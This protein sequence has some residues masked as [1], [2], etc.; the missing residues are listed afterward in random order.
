MESV[1]FSIKLVFCLEEQQCLVTSENT[2]KRTL[3][4]DNIAK[5]VKMSPWVKTKGANILII[6]K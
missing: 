5:Q 3:A 4:M 1:L 2:L 6:I